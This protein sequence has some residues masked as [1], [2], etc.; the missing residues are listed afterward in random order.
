MII[1]ICQLS[2]LHGQSNIVRRVAA[3]TGAA[4]EAGAAGVV[5]NEYRKH[6]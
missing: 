3:S 5:G 4:G 2:Q 6:G 1:Q